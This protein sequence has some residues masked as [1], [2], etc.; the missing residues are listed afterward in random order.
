MLRGPLLQVSAEPF[1]AALLSK[2]NS[3]AATKPICQL[4]TV[5][6]VFD[7]VGQTYIVHL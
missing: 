7:I 5:Y 3:P 2:E 6:K 1:S 4:D